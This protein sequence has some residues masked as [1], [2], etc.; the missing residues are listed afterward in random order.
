MYLPGSASIAL[1]LT[2]LTTVFWGSWANSFKVTRSYPFPLF[3]WDYVLGV[4]L[5]SL[6]FAF[7]LGSHG[8][9]GEPFLANLQASDRSDWFMALIGGAVFNIANLLL[10]AATDI[11][12]LAVAF[13]LAIGIAM[14]E[15]VVL[16]Y[17]LQ[18]AGNILYLGLGVVLA[19]AAVLFNAR[20]YKALDAQAADHQS[21]SR[22]G[23]I[24]S[25]ISGV[26]MGGWAPFVTRAMTHGH[27]MTP[28]SVTVLFG[29][30]AFLC[31]LVVN[32]YF[33]KRPLHGDPV[34][35]SGY[36]RAGARNHLLGLVGGIAWGIGGSFN[37]I[38]AGLVGIPISYAIGQASPL[39]AATWGIFVWHEFTGA[40]KLAWRSLQWMFALYVAAIGLLALAYTG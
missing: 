37:L 22:K 33:M 5:C 29:I 39:I 28:Y 24:V 10:V 26:L 32:P 23:I 40:P 36:W 31:N 20:A 34:S 38:A 16:S 15:G 6:G 3:Y 11:A 13:P 2:I 27:V 9:S 18:P 17:A 12:G 14:V 4:I 30:G 19:I 8:S 1:L 21:T 7:T 25:L 35:F